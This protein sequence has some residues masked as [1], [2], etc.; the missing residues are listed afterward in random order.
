MALKLFKKANFDSADYLLNTGMQFAEKTGDD[1][2]IAKFYIYQSNVHYFTKDANIGL[3]TLK[4]AY[5][6]LTKVPSYELHNKYLMLGGMF[7]EK[8]QKNDSALHY[9]HQCELLN[10]RE[11]PYR[12]WFVYTL[13]ALMFQQAEAFTESEKY[14]NK[15]YELTKT[16]VTKPIRVL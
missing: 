6:Y 15:A 12:S 9:Y 2:L 1:E 11:N 13:T 7:F 8:L 5:P 10:N 14:F 4:Q 3:H 16:R